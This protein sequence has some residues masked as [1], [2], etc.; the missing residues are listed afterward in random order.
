MISSN[1]KLGSRPTKNI[2]TK[3]TKNIKIKFT[4]LESK[5]DNGKTAGGM[6]IDFKI[7]PDPQIDPMVWAVELINKFQNIRPE[8]M[9]NV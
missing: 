7:P 4:K 1:L 6:L 3:K 9:Y 8:Q 2:K 5:I